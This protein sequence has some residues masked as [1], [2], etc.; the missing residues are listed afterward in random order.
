MPEETNLMNNPAKV[1]DDVRQPL[2]ADVK[3]LRPGD[4]FTH[5]GKTY[6]VVAYQNVTH[7]DRRSGGK[8]TLQT[9]CAECGIRFRMTVP[10]GAW[11]KGGALPA[12]CEA[13]WLTPQ[14]PTAPTSSIR[15][16]RAEGSKPHRSNAS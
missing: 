13:H 11:L 9:N 6:Q 12:R 3:R 7:R 4:R 14:R 1:T 10:Y 15:V 16:W 2:V 8:L 5:Q